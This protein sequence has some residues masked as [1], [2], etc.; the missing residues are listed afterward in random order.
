MFEPLDEL[1]DNISKIA[2][3]PVRFDM[4]RHIYVYID[5]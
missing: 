3:F 4:C 1:A 5:V 2:G